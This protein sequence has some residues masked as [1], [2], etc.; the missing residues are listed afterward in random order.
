MLIPILLT[1][2]WQII[3]AETNLVGFFKQKLMALDAGSP[4]LSNSSS[5]K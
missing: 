3:V 4:I 2:Q 5:E 1:A